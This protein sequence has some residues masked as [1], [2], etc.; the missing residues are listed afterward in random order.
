MAAP[1]KRWFEKFKPRE[2][3][4]GPRPAQRQDSAGGDHVESTEWATRYLRESFR[5]NAPG[6]A[7]Q[8]ALSLSKQ[9]MLGVTYLAVNTFATQASQCEVNL[10]EEDLDDP[11][12]RKPLSRYD[13]ASELIHHPNEDDSFGDLVEMAA[14]QYALTGMGL[15]WL[16]HDH[17]DPHDVPREM[18][19]LSTAS[20]LP[21]PISPR[22][23]NGAYLVQPWY[24]AGPY[25]MI[26]VQQGVGSII[27]AEQV[28]RIKKPHPFFRWTGYATLFAISQQMDAARMI[29]IARSSHFEQG[30]EPS[31]LLTFDPAVFRPDPAQ[32]ERLR[33]QFQ[34][35]WAGPR[36][37]GRIAIA[38]P[39]MDV[40][41]LS[42][43]P[44]DMAYQDGWSQLLDFG[45]AAFN[46]NK[47][48]CGM[49][50]GIT[51]ATLFA[52][53]KAF[54]LMCLGPFL[55]KLSY[56]ISHKILHPHF[57]R[58][59]FA[60]IDG[61]AIEDD[62]IRFKE[63]DAMCKGGIAKIGEI[64]KKLKLE[65]TDKDD[66]WYEGPGQ[67]QEQGAGAQGGEGAPG[68]EGAAG[69]AAGNP[70]AAL[71]GGAKDKQAEN[72]AEK[73]RPE[74][75]AGAGGLGPRKSLHDRHEQLMGRLEKAMSN[76]HAKPYRG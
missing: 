52:S 13:D 70:L 72:P 54:Y 5:R 12:S 22:Y 44:A 49:S 63:I 50:D 28:I 46:I 19:T 57:D 20:V 23:P 2:S 67:Q 47:S 8:D 51:Y 36:N 60:E 42:T 56:S 21:Q 69:G 16:P 62:D 76:G 7:D 41:T 37:A 73:T 40:K 75:S 71:L 31:A 10:W 58:S 9:G 4:G 55:K 66:E 35:I 17:T 48:V 64:R 59:F 14:Q 74:N 29:D 34:A 27:P 38:P 18:Y 15:L 32:V 68:E 33:A 25:A 53:L 65:K 43:S 6:Y 26:P 30:F 3:R 39:G 11:E 45:L 1:A 61:M 24:P